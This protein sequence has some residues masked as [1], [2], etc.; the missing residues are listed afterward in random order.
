MLRACCGR[1]GSDS[2]PGLVDSVPQAPGL[3]C[4]VRWFT[5]LSGPL[6]GRGSRPV[7]HEGSSGVCMLVERA[8]VVQWAELVGWQGTLMILF[9]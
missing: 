5:V 1:G 9:L 7:A 6:E 2:L 8:E 4:L 3:A